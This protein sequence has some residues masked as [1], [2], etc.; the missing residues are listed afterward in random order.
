MLL[1]VRTYICH[2]IIFGGGGGG[3]R[4]SEPLRESAVR[5]LVDADEGRPNR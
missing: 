3:R 5:G 2:L 1:K 4:S